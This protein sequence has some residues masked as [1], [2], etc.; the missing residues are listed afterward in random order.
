[1]KNVL[2]IFSVLDVMILWLDSGNAKRIF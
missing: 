2:C 1:L